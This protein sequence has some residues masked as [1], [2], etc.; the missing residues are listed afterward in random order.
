[1]HIKNF[2]EVP[3]QQTHGTSGNAVFL[4]VS[5]A[6]DRVLHMKLFVKLLQRK[7]SVCF[8]WL[9]KHQ[10]KEQMMQ[11]KRSICLNRFM[12]LMG[13]DNGEYWV[14]TCVLYI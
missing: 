1:M 2:T 6:F 13:W 8:V 5:N 9:L 7:V 11:I 10:Y 3:T 14:H 4:A 12:W